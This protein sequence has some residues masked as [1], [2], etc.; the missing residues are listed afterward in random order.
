MGEYPLGLLLSDRRPKT[1]FKRVSWQGIEPRTSSQRE[2]GA[3]HYTM[4][5]E[6]TESASLREARCLDRIHYTFYLVTCILHEQIS[7]ETFKRHPLFDA[8]ATEGSSTAKE[9]PVTLSGFRWQ[10]SNLWGISAWPSA[11]GPETENPVF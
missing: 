10:D 8:M 6:P 9:P 3:N 1:R 2:Q 7:T 11:F 4:G 5:P